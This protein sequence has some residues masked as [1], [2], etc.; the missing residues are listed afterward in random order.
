MEGRR[1]KTAT[2][3]DFDGGKDGIARDPDLGTVRR[4]SIKNVNRVG[5]WNNREMKADESTIRSLTSRRLT[6]GPSVEQARTEGARG[7]GSQS[8]WHMGGESSQVDTESHNHTDERCCHQAAT[9]G[10]FFLPSVC[11]RRKMQWR[12]ERCTSR[13]V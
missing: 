3:R 12:F 7:D 8:N 5:T 13:E 1:R 9:G 6:G 10:L 11:L 4:P 2:K